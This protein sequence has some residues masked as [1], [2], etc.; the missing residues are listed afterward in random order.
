MTTIAVGDQHSC[1]RDAKGAVYCW[2]QDINGQLGD[3]GSSSS[4][5]PVQTVG[6]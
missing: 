2:G 4:T 3:G 5:T 1:A 6:F